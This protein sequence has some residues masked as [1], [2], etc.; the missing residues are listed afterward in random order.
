MS[1]E[2]W[3]RTIGCGELRMDNLGETVTV[4]GW[5]NSVRSHG[6]LVFIDLRDRTG[7]VQLRTD[8]STSQELVDLADSARSETVIACTGHVKARGEK[9]VN[10]KIPT[11][12]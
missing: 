8:T 1:L 6:G 2:I 11:G 7:I 10:P 3:Q 5:A 4:N 12:E 9:D